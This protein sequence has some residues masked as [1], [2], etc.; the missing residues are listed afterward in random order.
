MHREPSEPTPMT[1][2]EVEKYQEEVRQAQ[3]ARADK[4][5][6]ELLEPDEA[7]QM[8]V[9]KGEDLV[10]PLEPT[11]EIIEKFIEAAQMSD[12]T[13]P[14]QAEALIA[15]I[16]SVDNNAR[17]WGVAHGRAL[18]RGET[19]EEDWK[20]EE[21]IDLELKDMELQEA[22]FTALGAASMCWQHIDRAGI[23]DSTRARLIGEQLALRIFQEENEH[24]KIEGDEELWRGDIPVI[25]GPGGAPTIGYAVG[26]LRNKRA[27]LTVRMRRDA[28]KDL[29]GVLKN[30]WPAAI[31]FSMLPQEH[32]K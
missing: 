5:V 4:I 14:E 10:A 15:L 18:E 26:M 22:V 13:F 29:I 12:S 3:A 17:N 16:K 8:Y 9:L 7:Q 6:D 11:R 23:F 2:E 25:L 1:P 20:G 24:D 27:E 19:E 21:A 30:N 28:G 32:R 31:Y